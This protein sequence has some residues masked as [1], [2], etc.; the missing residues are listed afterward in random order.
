MS[1]RAGRSAI[2]AT[3]VLYSAVLLIVFGVRHVRQQVERGTLFPQHVGT[4]TP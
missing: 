4:V 3:V 2:V 1:R